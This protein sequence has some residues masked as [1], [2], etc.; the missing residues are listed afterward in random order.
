MMIAFIPNALPASLE[1]PVYI[2]RSDS[3]IYYN[4]EGNDKTFV[5]F[6]RR[7]TSPMRKLVKSSRRRDP[8]LENLR[9]GS[10]RLAGPVET[11]R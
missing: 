9:K 4:E 11:A 1:A 2:I 10:R 5:Y 6:Q 3:L 7:M 8:V